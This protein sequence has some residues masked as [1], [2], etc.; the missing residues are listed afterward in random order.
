MSEDHEQ[1]LFAPPDDEYDEDDER[2]HSLD[3]TCETCIQNHP[4]RMIY[5]LND[6]DDDDGYSVCSVCHHLSFFNDECEN[7]GFGAE[8]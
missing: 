2:T 7:C 4:E 8:E 1:D 6:Q 5:L 3:C